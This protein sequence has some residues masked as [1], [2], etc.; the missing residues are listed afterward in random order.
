MCVTFKHCWEYVVCIL[1]FLNRTL[2]VLWASFFF[3]ISLC[4][5]LL[6]EIMYSPT[7]VHRCI[8]LEY[9]SFQLHALIFCRVLLLC[10]FMPSTNRITS[11]GLKLFVPKFT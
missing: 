5:C 11:E 7:R 3:L 4:I 2:N 6:Q 10:S 1:H 8:P 9:T